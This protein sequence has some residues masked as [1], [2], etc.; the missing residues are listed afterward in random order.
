MG[1]PLL[2]CLSLADSC[3]ILLILECESLFAIVVPSCQLPL[4]VCTSWKLQQL[5]VLHCKSVCQV[6]IN[7]HARGQMVFLVDILLQNLLPKNLC[8]LII[9]HRVKVI[10]S[11]G[12]WICKIAQQLHF[13][14]SKVIQDMLNSINCVEWPVLLSLHQVHEVYISSWKL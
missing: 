8:N 14:V 11:T 3:V 13:S 2:V 4:E 5:V 6:I 10:S 1:F 12:Y 7:F 9:P